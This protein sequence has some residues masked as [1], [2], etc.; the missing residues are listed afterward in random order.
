MTPSSCSKNQLF[1]GAWRRGCGT[2]EADM[3][4]MDMIFIRRDFTTPEKRRWPM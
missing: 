2:S 4:P 3:K 1:Q